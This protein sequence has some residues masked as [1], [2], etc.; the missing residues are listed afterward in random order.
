MYIIETVQKFLSLIPTL[1]INSMG[2]THLSQFCCFFIILYDIF[3][4]YSQCPNLLYAL[5]N[6]LVVSAS[7]TDHHWMARIARA[8]RCFIRM[9]Y[10]FY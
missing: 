8:I 3:S 4:L 6:L 10:I 1:R 7:L 5:Y 9:R 2:I